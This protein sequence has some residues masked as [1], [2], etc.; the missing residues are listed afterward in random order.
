VQ[1]AKIAQLEKRIQTLES[2]KAELATQRDSALKE[3][4]GIVSQQPEFLSLMQQIID[5]ALLLQTARSSR[6]PS[7]TSLSAKLKDLKEPGMM[8]QMQLLR[9][10]R[11]CSII[12]MVRVDS[13]L[14]KCLTS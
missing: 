14:L 3:V 10:S 4:E 5:M 7:S 2:D 1:A 13:M 6:K 9:L 12:T 11:P 8:S